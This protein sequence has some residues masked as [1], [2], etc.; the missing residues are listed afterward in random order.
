MDRIIRKLGSM[1]PALAALSCMFLFVGPMS[2]FG[3]LMDDDQLSSADS[4]ML[5]LVGFTMISFSIGA[6]WRAPWTR[7]VWPVCFVVLTVHALVFRSE[8]VLEQLASYLAWFFITVWYFFRK[9][10]VVMYFQV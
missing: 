9:R 3:L 10:D 7:Y 8:R 4:T 5:G 6:F 2:V 1:P